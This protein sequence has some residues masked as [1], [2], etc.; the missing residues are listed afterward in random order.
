MT[1]VAPLGLSP[2]LPV[3]W[4][5]VVPAGGADTV[6]VV[7][8]TANTVTAIDIPSRSVLWTTP[9]LPGGLTNP[10][11]I[12]Q[13]HLGLYVAGN[14]FGYMGLL[15]PA[16]GAVLEHGAP[17]AGTHTYVTP[18][19]NNP[20]PGETVIVTDNTAPGSVVLTASPFTNALSFTVGV[21]T[22]PYGAALRPKTREVWWSCG[23]TNEVQVM[24]LDTFGITHT[25]TVGNGPNGITFADDG[26][27][28][29]VVNNTDCTVS[30][31][32]ATTYTVTA[33]VGN[34]PAPVSVSDANH[35]VF[36]D[37]TTL[38]VSFGAGN[39]FGVM[40]TTT[41]TAIGG[42]VVGA[43]T[44]PIDMALVGGKVWVTEKAANWVGVWDPATGT[45]VE[46]IA[47]D[48]GPQRLCVGTR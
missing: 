29:Y 38:W 25:I 44:D 40:D 17:M 39:S 35:A 1:R 31:V 4:R 47:T 23:G 16:T 9:T 19:V 11:G 42:Y 36:V 5:P 12:T 13:G 20:G 41:N 14:H 33:T 10:L 6:W 27:T 43:V 21:G 45:R 3:D 46:T 8:N 15:D 26:S 2:L 34:W 48:Q 22:D 7:N 37:P 30:V 32:D 18:V 24:D 28:A